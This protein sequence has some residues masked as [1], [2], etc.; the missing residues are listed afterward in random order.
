MK[1]L[2]DRTK[3]VI[4]R[5]KDLSCRLKWYGDN[6]YSTL[7]YLI[8]LELPKVASFLG[9]YRKAPACGIRNTR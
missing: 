1:C 9:V 6:G 3:L 5:K 8:V 4:E 7:R 2:N